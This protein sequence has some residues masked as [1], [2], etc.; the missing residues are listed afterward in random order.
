MSTRQL[1]LFFSGNHDSQKAYALAQ[2]SGINFRFIPTSNEDA[3]FILD[4]YH[5]HTGLKKIQEFID[6]EKPS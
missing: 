5:D 3:P 6:L 1:F 2:Q 4:S